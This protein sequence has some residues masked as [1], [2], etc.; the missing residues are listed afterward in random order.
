VLVHH[1]EHID[2]LY[3]EAPQSLTL[4]VRIF[5]ERGTLAVDEMNSSMVVDMVNI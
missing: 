4:S 2:T 1:K 3:D 5:K